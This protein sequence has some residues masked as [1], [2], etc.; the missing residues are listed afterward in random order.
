M[1][2]SSRIRELPPLF[3]LLI[4]QVVALIAVS[5]GLPWYFLIICFISIISL[6]RS[7]SSRLFM[8]I[9]ALIIISSA[10][11]LQ[12]DMLALRAWKELSHTSVLVHARVE[13]IAPC[14]TKSGYQFKVF[15]KVI[16]APLAAA[17]VGK[18]IVVFVRSFPACQVADDIKTY[19]TVGALKDTLPRYG[20]VAT[21]FMQRLPIQS[22]A[23]TIFSW[24][25]QL[26]MMRYQ[27]MRSMQH[28][29]SKPVA[30]LVA[31]LFTGACGAS[32]AVMTEV[33]SLCSR[34]GISHYL[35]R[36]GLHVALLCL[37]WY[38]VL[39]FFGCPLLW[40]YACMLG[41][42]GVFALL[43]YPSVSFWRAGIFL[44]VRQASLL[45]GYHMTSRTAILVTVITL[46]LLWPAALFAVDFQLTVGLAVMV[47]VASSSLRLLV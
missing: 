34:W 46:L 37:M 13:E 19:I 41:A 36:S 45:A 8:A 28:N 4:V 14:A 44:A 5:Y 27:L 39:T 35:A 40:R 3:L 42:L 15:L 21:F 33:R 29:L 17:S 30:Y 18:S 12:G 47:M 38:W 7:L 23:K 32:P 25:R 9:N 6:A 26:S 1:I 11:V 43:T 2:L 22:C 20:A 24:K 10:F 31:I 16:D